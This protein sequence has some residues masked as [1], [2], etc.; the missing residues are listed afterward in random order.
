[1][2]QAGR[3]ADKGTAGGR[4]LLLG[5]GIQSLGQRQVPLLTAVQAGGALPVVSS[6]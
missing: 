1:M 4:S 3:A 6:V 5:V 2:M